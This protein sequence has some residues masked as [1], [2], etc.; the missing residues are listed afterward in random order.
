MKKIILNIF[1]FL[2]LSNC[3]YSPLLIRNIQDF[4]IQIEVIEGDRLINNLKI[5]SKE[6]KNIKVIHQDALKIDFNKIQKISL[7]K[8]AVSYTHLRAHE[9]VLDLVC[10]LLLEK[11]KIKTTTHTKQHKTC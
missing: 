5:F 4:N 7:S 8:D 1:L 10:R 3:G 2:I 9:T 11:K 6:F